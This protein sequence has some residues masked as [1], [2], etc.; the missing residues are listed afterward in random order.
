M[1]YFSKVKTQMYWFSWRKWK[2]NVLRR[3]DVMSEVFRR[4]FKWN[5]LLFVVGINMFWMDLNPLAQKAGLFTPLRSHLHFWRFEAF[6][7]NLKGNSERTKE[8]NS[9]QFSREDNPEPGWR[10]T[11]TRVRAES[12]RRLAIRSIGETV[13][14]HAYHAS[15]Y[16]LFPL[17]RSRFVQGG[18]PAMRHGAVPRI[19]LRRDRRRRA[20]KSIRR[21]VRRRAAVSST[22][23]MERDDEDTQNVFTKR[24]KKREKWKSKEKKKRS[25][26]DFIFWNTTGDATLK[27]ETTSLYL[28]HNSHARLFEYRLD[29]L[30]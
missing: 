8:I 27:R 4:F 23:R 5:M 26:D 13:A 11:Q 16:F 2:H 19:L 12:D 3:N 10:L 28:R 9:A 30:L 20:W 25:A 6:E 14:S 18:F 24:E 22:S 15:T 7:T 21:P 29:R 1:C 17:P